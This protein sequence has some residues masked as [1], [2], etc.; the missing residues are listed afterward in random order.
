VFFAF[1]SNDFA[2]LSVLFDKVQQPIQRLVVI[3]VFLAFEDHLRSMS[4]QKNLRQQQANY[5][6]FLPR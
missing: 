2:V 1:V 4:R 3:I 5:P 6:T